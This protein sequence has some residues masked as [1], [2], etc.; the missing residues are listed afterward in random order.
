MSF[1]R[2]CKMRTFNVAKQEGLCS[3]WPKTGPRSDRM[4]DRVLSS[5]LRGLDRVFET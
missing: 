2:L 3:I 1:K 4:E 5:A